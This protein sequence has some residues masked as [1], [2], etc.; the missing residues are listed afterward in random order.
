MLV[1]IPYR[2]VELLFKKSNSRLRGIIYSNRLILD[3]TTIHPSPL[4]ATVAGGGQA[5]TI[6]G[7]ADV[8]Y[9]I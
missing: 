3:A 4:I 5:F 8:K 1:A 2:K 6:G 7:K 9:I